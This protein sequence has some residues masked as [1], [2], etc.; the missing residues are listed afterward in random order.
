[1]KDTLKTLPKKRLILIMRL[2]AANA[3]QKGDMNRVKFVMDALKKVEKSPKRFF[4][5]AIG[6]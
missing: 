2:D 3:H 4:T 1:M 6:E 5:V